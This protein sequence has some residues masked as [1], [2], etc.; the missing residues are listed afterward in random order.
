M[1]GGRN[2]VNQPTLFTY[3][4]EQSRTHAIA[5]NSNQP[6]ALVILWMIVGNR[7]VSDC[8]MSLLAIMLQMRASWNG[9][10]FGMSQF[11]IP[12][13][14][15]KESFHQLQERIPLKVPC[16]TDDRSVGM[17]VVCME[18]FAVVQRGFF[19]PLLTAKR[20]SAINITKPQSLQFLKAFL[21]GIV[22]DR[23]QFKQGGLTG[24]FELIV[25]KMGF[26][27]DRCSDFQRRFQNTRHSSH[28]ERGVEGCYGTGT[29]HTKK[30]QLFHNI[31]ARPWSGPSLTHFQCHSR[32]S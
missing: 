31:A 5:E 32:K 20:R 24:L 12:S 4:G 8:N 14:I 17:V 22:F 18:L 16:K 30:V 29:F 19:E 6:S 1:R 2:G 28:T 11:R 3:L 21:G 13:P 27:N 7:I 10:H 25:R 23:R 15:A 9:N 26:S